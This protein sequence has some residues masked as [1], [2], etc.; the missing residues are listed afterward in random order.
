MWD[1]W[2]PMRCLICTNKVSKREKKLIKAC[3]RT[4][5]AMMEI[6]STC[7]VGRNKVLAKMKGAGK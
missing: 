6:C 3:Q 4:G 5:V 2:K 1:G 7:V